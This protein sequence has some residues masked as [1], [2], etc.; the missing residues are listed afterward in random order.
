[1]ISPSAA[2]SGSSSLFCGVFRAEVDGVADKRSGDTATVDV[3]T[4]GLPEHVPEI[5]LFH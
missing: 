1:L 4:E 3:Q 2:G 5:Y